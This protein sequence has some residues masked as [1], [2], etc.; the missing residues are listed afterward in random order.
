MDS[1]Y[2]PRWPAVLA[3]FTI[4]GLYAALPANLIIG[5]RWLPFL[6]ALGFNIPMFFLKNQGRH[7]HNQILSYILLGILTGFM[8]VSLT[9]LVFSLPRHQEAPVV[10]LRSA[11]LL[12]VTNILLFASWYWRLD[13][14][15]PHRR[16]ARFEHLDGAFLFPPMMLEKGVKERLGLIAWS[17]LFVDYLYLSFNTS[18]A[19]ST[20][21]TTPISRWAKVLMIIQAGVSLAIIS[22]LAARSVNIL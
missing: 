3:L 11:V 2:E 20:T 21:D 4:G 16:E 5:P 9:L 19:F 13:A 10:L 18:A 15:G 7:G 22:L 1:K 6:V 17:P 12:W 8:L 14:G